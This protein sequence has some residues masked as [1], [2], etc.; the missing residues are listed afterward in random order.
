VQV[1]G[2]RGPAAA[3]AAQA[4][5]VELAEWPVRLPVELEPVQ[6]VEL[7]MDRELPV[8]NE[9][10]RALQRVLQRREL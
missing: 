6:Q 9:R 2:P 3:Q 7:V 10:Q 8:D 4:G 5:A 1:L